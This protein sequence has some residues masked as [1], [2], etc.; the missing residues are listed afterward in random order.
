MATRSVKNPLL[1]PSFAFPPNAIIKRK[2]L[3][4]TAIRAG[5]IGCI[6]ALNQIPMDTRISLVIAHGEGHLK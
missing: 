3:S 5:W 6:I 2:P 4:E 1:I